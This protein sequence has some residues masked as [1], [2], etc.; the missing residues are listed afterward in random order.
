M[1]P[2]A[3]LRP[4][5]RPS[6]VREFRSY[7]GES[8]GYVLRA[9]GDTGTP[10]AVDM[11]VSGNYLD[12]SECEISAARTVRERRPLSVI[13]DESVRHART[14]AAPASGTRPFVRGSGVGGGAP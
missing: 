10:D 12:N 4:A 13:G 11:P 9:R 5:V 2:E 6:G 14:H 3:R 7:P 8:L 1:N